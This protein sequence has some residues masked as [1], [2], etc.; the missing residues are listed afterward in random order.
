MVILVKGG[1]NRNAYVQRTA[2]SL[3]AADYEV[4]V[5]CGRRHASSASDWEQADGFAVRIVPAPPVRGSRRERSTEQQ[6]ARLAIRRDQLARRIDELGGT[7]A[8]RAASLRARLERRILA[9]RLA[10]T[11][12]RAKHAGERARKLATEGK[13]GRRLTDPH[14][15]AQYEA[16][17]WPD[18]RKLRPDV[19]HVVDV[20]GLSTGR[21]AGR[22]AM[23]WIYDAHEPKRHG[24][25]EAFD[26]I[27]RQQVVEYASQADGVV[28]TTAALAEVLIAELSLSR[29]P[30]LVHNT[31]PLRAG[32]APQP[33]LREAAGVGIDDPLLVYTGVV[34]IHRRLGIVLEA[35]TMLP[36]VQ[37][38]LVV[39]VNDPLTKELLAQADALGVSERVHVVPKVMPESIVPYSAEADV[40]VFP[41]ARY[42]GGDLALPNKLF[43]YLHAGLPMV[44]SDSPA[45][46]EFVRRYGLGG[47]VPVDDATGWA[48]AIERALAPPFYR[49]RVPDWEALKQ[50]WCWERQAEALVDLYREVLD[51]R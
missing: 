36:E 16:A 27:R 28:A 43:E 12:Y 38:A 50:E 35:M 17:W 39:R 20:S 30:T 48:Q 7:A 46:A 32:P 21:R 34:T 37:L 15:L 42:P 19:V 23:R 24:G 41:L 22:E 47:S 45:M 5:L 40:G 49:D 14:D 51:S 10:R 3:Q 1:I 26:V 9:R 6:A 33:G 18:V 4:F 11:A 13:A 2:S 8:G 29:M 25:E 44:V 31:P